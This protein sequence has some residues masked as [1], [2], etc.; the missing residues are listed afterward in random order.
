MEFQDYYK[1]LGVSRNATSDEIKKS[2]RKL[3]RKYHP[4]VSKEAGA[5]EKF[6]QVREAYEV[7]K[8]PEKRKAY[9]AMGAGWKQ[10]EGFTPPPG[11]NFHPEGGS[12]TCQGFRAG[13]F[14]DFFEMLF[15]RVGRSSRS[16]AQQEFKQRGQDQHSCINISLEEAFNGAARVLN[17]QI[18]QINLRT[19]QLIYQTRTL[20]V[21]IP[22]GV[23][24]GQQIRLPGQGA[25]GIGGAS[26]GDLY[27][28]IRLEPH[29]LYTVEGK[30]IFL[31]LP[32][33]PW[34][35]ALGA[36]ISIPTLGGPVGLTLPAN[37][38]TGQKLRLKGR[39]LRGGGE[40]GDQ[41]VLLKI[42]IP[43]PKNDQQKQLYRQMA[44]QMYFD[45]RKDLLERSS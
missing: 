31:N 11:W 22:P 6:K 24:E 5:E 26:H 30:N 13:D 29:S 16:W 28:E 32:V 45:P 43:E 38:Q 40:P 8:D 25:P 23:T 39:G 21:K 41:Y 42:Y 12:A 37:S 14:S 9:D 27:L 36:K 7:L 10:G 34:E 2:Y 4:D 17:L 33:T 35:A 20:R 44:E 18:P 19:E 15:G 3:A 1:V